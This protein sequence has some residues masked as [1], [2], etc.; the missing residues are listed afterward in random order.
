M[1]LPH[2]NRLMRALGNDREVEVSVGSDV[3]RAEDV[4]LLCSDG[5]SGMLKAES[6]SKE[7]TSGC[8]LRDM[9]EAL[10]RK[11]LAAGGRDNA[12]ALLVRAVQD[13][14]F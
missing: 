13:A 11:A 3:L 4:F 7:L 5:V 2:I 1:D 12:S 9:G 10:I 8:D 14:S 6:I